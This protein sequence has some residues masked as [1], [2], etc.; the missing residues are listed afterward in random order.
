M[1]RVSRT[2]ENFTE[3]G[4]ESRGVGQTRYHWP[5]YVAK[6]LIDNALE[7]GESDVTIGV[8][9]STR[10][11]GIGNGNRITEI[12]VLDDGPGM[13]EEMIHAIFEDVDH[14]VG[15][16]SQYAIPTRGDQ[17]NALM[18]ILGIQYV[19]NPARPLVVYSRG[20][21]YTI[22]AMKRLNDIEV[23]IRET[24][25]SH[26]CGFGVT[27][28]FGDNG[29]SN[30]AHSTRSV[31]RNLPLLNPQAEFAVKFGGE[32]M[33]LPTVSDSTVT[34]GTETELA[35]WLSPNEFA[36][37]YIADKAADPDMTLTEFITQFYGL[38]T[39]AN[40][41]IT[42]ADERVLDGDATGEQQEQETSEGE[43]EATA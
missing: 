2:S 33:V 23:D 39:K 9:V 32:D 28:G 20:Q 5:R 30:D 34:P 36:D 43:T 24:Q 10:S 31:V 13:D 29:E 41:V 1:H 8:D 35:T 17:G 22:R 21:E 14:Y 11:L 7:A 12:T 42:D 19:V 27:V 26:A 38:K 3:Q 25:P 40:E 4:L 37:R 6:E 15:T 16:K 18:T